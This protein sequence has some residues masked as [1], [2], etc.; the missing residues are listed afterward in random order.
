MAFP[1]H[2]HHHTNVWG[3]NASASM[4]MD[5]VERDDHYGVKVDLPGIPKEDISVNVEGDALVISAERNLEK[6][7]DKDNYHLM[8]RHYGKMSRRV[9][10]PKD[11]DVEK[12]QAKFEN[13][14]LD[15]TLPRAH[16]KD[17]SK[18][19]NIQ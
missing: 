17:N 12:A 16:Q 2:L 10:I 3:N 15:L 7:E 11:A 19:I 13:G 6:R 18:S 4:K 1:H 9:R 5:V 14:V 8:E